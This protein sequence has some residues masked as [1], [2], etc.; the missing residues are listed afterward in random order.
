VKLT[1]AYQNR[2]LFLRRPA[3]QLR[4]EA[5]LIPRNANID[6]MV[7]SIL[8]GWVIG[9]QPAGIGIREVGTLIRDNLSRFAPHLIE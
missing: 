9:Q 1:F 5:D 6:I 4:P 2:R 3:D 8:I 7:G